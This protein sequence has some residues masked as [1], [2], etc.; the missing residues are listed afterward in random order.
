MKYEDLIKMSAK[1]L[2]ARL[3]DLNAQAA[4]AVRIKSLRWILM[5]VLY[6]NYG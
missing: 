5:R 4:T 3:K 6:H 1:D 2:K